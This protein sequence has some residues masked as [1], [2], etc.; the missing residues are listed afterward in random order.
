MSCMQAPKHRSCR[1]CWGCGDLE[2]SEPI[3]KEG[4]GWT[5]RLVSVW[6]SNRKRCMDE[7]EQQQ[8]LRVICC[9]FKGSSLPE[10]KQ[11]TPST[12]LGLSGYRD[13]PVAASRAKPVPLRYR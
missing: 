3:L 9:A 5:E 6:S 8:R 12:G 11:R 7:G 4:R 1:L 2:A 10:I 13:S